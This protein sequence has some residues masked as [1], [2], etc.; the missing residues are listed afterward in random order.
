MTEGKM[1]GWHQRLNGYESVQASRVGE[2][3]KPGMLQSTG[4]QRIRHK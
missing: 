4:S 3:Q 1:V 2:G